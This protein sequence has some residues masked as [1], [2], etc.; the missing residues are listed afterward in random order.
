M[1]ELLEL[2]NVKKSYSIKDRI[3]PILNGVSLKISHGEFVAIMGP[4]GSGK[5]TLLHIMGGLDHATS[6]RVIMGGKDITRYDDG[7]LARLRNQ[8]MGFVFQN[9][10]L[11]NYYTALENVCLPLIYRNQL[12]EKLNDAKQLLEHVGLG[13]RL[14]HRPNELSGG[15]R[16]RV[17]IARALVNRPRLVFADEP[18]GNLDSKTGAVVMEILKEI[19]RAGTAVILITHDPHIASEA[20]RVIHI[21]DGML[22]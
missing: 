3:I 14:H 1:S 7:S 13:K 17:A 20:R 5:S 16:Q 2:D 12:P 8:S 9:F 18:T 15:E 21:E 4:S 6:G 11:L 19:N 10:Y 22:V